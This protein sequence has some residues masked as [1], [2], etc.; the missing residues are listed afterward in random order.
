MTKRAAPSPLVLRSRTSGITS[1]SLQP[2]GQLEHLSGTEDRHLELAAGGF[3]RQEV[4]NL[5]QVG[6]LCL[7]TL[8][9]EDDV[10]AERD[11]VSAQIGDHGCSSN[12]HLVGRRVLRHGLDDEARRPGGQVQEVG[13]GV[14]EDLALEAA[15]EGALLEQEL[16]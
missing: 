15:P 7:E 3:A 10:S 16:L 13:L 11:L 1:Y 2:S 5:R 12:P 9:S 8:H 6:R 14:R 4:P